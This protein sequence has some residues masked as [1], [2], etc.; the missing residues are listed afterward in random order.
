VGNFRHLPEVIRATFSRGDRDGAEPRIG[1]RAYEQIER[2]TPVGGISPLPAALVAT[3]EAEGRTG[4]L[5]TLP[6]TVPG[7][8]ASGR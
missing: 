4:W 5:A 1:I 3:A 6:D 2:V 7:S 8:S